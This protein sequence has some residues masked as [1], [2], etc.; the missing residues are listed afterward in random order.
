MER[1]KAYLFFAVVGFVMLALVGL[2]ESTGLPVNGG[3]VAIIVAALFMPVVA[4]LTWSWW[5]DD[6]YISD[7]TVSTDGTVQWTRRF[8]MS[9]F[10]GKVGRFAIS[11]VAITAVAAY[12]VWQSAQ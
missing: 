6:V 1:L 7:P 3:A 5:K 11:S 9:S 2:I 12:F 8:H 10:M 4:A